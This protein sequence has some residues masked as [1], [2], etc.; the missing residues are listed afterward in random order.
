SYKPDMENFQY[1]LVHL[2]E[3]GIKQARILHVA[4][5][6]YHDHIPA[7][8]LGLATAWIHR[9]H[10]KKGYGATRAPTE[11]V[12]PDFRFNSMSE[13]ALSHGAARR[14]AASISA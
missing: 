7:K 11:D 10:D 13:F 3:M 12:K 8:K 4:E 5:S 9:R 1:L 6:L 2:E 14:E